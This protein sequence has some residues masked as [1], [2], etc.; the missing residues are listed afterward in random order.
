M[1]A[2]AR[3]CA[4]VLDEAAIVRKIDDIASVVEKVN[5]REMKNAEGV[6]RRFVRKYNVILKTIALKTLIYNSQQ[7]TRH[8]NPDRSTHR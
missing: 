7:S 8:S 5:R 4:S 1:A 2:G 3:A 6:R